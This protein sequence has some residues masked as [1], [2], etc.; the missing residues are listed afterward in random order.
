M[1]A[2]GLLLTGG[3]VWF[4]SRWPRAIE[5][6]DKDFHD[7]VPTSSLGG[8]L[9]SRIKSLQIYWNIFC[10]F[11]GSFANIVSVMGVLN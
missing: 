4:V 9:A 2:I 1:I 10:V 11:S 7:E 6:K 3:L 5:E 8:I